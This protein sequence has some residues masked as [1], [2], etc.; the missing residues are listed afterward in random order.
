MS[1]F[2]LAAQ[3]AV[4]LQSQLAYLLSQAGAEESLHLISFFINMFHQTLESSNMLSQRVQRSDCYIRSLTLYS[5]GADGQR[6]VAIF[7]LHRATCSV[8]V[9]SA[10]ILTEHQNLSKCQI[11][12]QLLTHSFKTHVN[13]CVSAKL[14]TVKKPVTITTPLFISVH[15]WF[16]FRPTR[17][18][19]TVEYC[20]KKLCMA[21]TTCPIVHP[22]CAKSTGIN[23]RFAET[24]FLDCHT[25][26]GIN[27]T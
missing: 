7:A 1:G 13:I 19:I 2:K 21:L 12:G 22:P 18:M 20:P 5:D 15:L 9:S 3:V 4:W 23:I 6:F 10:T 16:Y 25:S 8:A 26:G 14:N 17:Q 11:K 27:K 24:D